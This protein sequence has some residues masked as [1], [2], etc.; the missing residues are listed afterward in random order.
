M[1][2]ASNVSLAICCDF[3]AEFNICKS[4][5]YFS[6]NKTCLL[7]DEIDLTPIK[8]TQQDQCE[9]GRICKK[10]EIKLNNFYN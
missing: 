6:G 7:F 10:I 9:S 3:C 2:Q 5:T 8:C 1:N 4:Y